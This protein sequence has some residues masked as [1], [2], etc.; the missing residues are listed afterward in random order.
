MYM[1]RIET[2]TALEVIKPEPQ[3]RLIVGIAFLALALPYWAV[4]LL[5]QMLWSDVKR[6]GRFAGLAGAT[7]SDAIR[8]R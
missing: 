5:G 3:G 6:I 4:R 8:S 1:G 7:Y 2:R